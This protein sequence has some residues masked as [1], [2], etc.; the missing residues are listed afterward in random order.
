MRPFPA[1]RVRALL[2]TLGE[3]LG[4][5]RSL[6]NFTAEFFEP[7]TRFD[8]GKLSKWKTA[9]S[10]QAKDRLS[11]ASC[12]SNADWPLIAGTRRGT[13][14]KA[15]TEAATMNLAKVVKLR[16][17]EPTPP[18]QMSDAL[19]HDV[20]AEFETIVANTNCIAHAQ[21]YFVDASAN[22]PAECRYI[23]ESLK[24]AYVVDAAAQKGNLSADERLRLHQQHTAPVFEALR[25]WITRQF[26]EKL[27]E[28]NSQLGAAL[29]YLRKHWETLPLFLRVVGAPLDNHI[30]ERA[31]KKAVIHRMISLFYKTDNGAAV[32]DLHM[33]LIQ[34]CELNEVNP[35]DYL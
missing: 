8:F 14:L 26:D 18:N 29:D 3:E 27:V 13:T 16:A 5:N 34:T 20:S 35:F 15:L 11:R 32:G 9:S 10:R 1:M 25:S 33:S 21:R 30:C 31:L 28:K 17:A 2:G 23:L 7:L 22:F 4:A 6:P 24:V 19:S 12:R